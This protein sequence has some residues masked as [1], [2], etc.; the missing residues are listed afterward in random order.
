[1]LNVYYL[2]L[3]LRGLHG[4][5]RFSHVSGMER[6]SINRWYCL[7]TELDFEILILT[8]VSLSNSS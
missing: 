8:S 6:E 5:P 4:L 1:M 7:H 3:T 2:I